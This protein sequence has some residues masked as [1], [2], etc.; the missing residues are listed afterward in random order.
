M[1]SAALRLFA[2]HSV[3][4][5]RSTSSASSRDPSPSALARR[6]SSSSV[7][8]GFQSTIVRSA[9]GAESP[10]TTV[11]SSPVNDDASSAGFAI[12]A[13]G[14]Q[15]LRLG[16]VDGRQPPQAPQHVAHVRAEDAAVHVGLVDDDVLE[17]REHVAPA[18]VMGQDAEVEHVRVGED[19]VR[20]RPHLAPLVDRRV[21]VV[22][23]RPH[24]GHAE[25]CEAAR[26][27]LRERLRRIEVERARLRVAGDRVEHG[28]VEGERLAARRA[29]RDGDV[30]AARCGRPCLGL[31]LEQ[32]GDA[33]ALERRHDA[34]VE[35]RGKRR[36]R[37]LPRRLARDI[38]D[39]L[40]GEQLVGECGDAHPSATT[41]SVRG[42]KPS[43]S[44]CRLATRSW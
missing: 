9:R 21:A 11:A 30:L 34:L 15:E 14:E 32:R 42:S 7:T 33:L 4:R 35:L 29:C 3:R 38:G 27:I 5:P 2:K 23:R 43:S 17:V 13:D 26:L 22:D 12:V 1:S 40:S 10:E 16:P 24:A 20:P 37:R 28:E 41:S 6:L 31:M 8:G 36:R 18:V 19:R 39:L 25:G 44:S